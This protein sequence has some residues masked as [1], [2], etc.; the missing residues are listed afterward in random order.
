[1]NSNAPATIDISLI[2]E[3]GTLVFNCDNTNNPKPTKDRSGSG[4]GLENTR[5]R[6]NLLYQGRY[7]W[8]QTITPDNIYHVKITLQP[9]RSFNSNLI[10][11]NSLSHNPSSPIPSLS[12]SMA[13][14]VTYLST[15]LPTSMA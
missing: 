14:G 11:H 10:S 1:M 13:S 8:E 6:M 2:Q 7:Q 12:A 4:I 15:R 9:R 5:R 3:D